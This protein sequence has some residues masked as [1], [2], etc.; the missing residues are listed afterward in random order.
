MLEFPYQV[1]SG[2][3]YIALLVEALRWVSWPIAAMVVAHVLKD[4]I[5]AAANRLRGLAYGGVKADFASQTS[6]A[7][8]L[9]EPLAQTTKTPN[10]LIERNMSEALKQVSAFVE[11]ELKAFPEEQKIEV[12]IV[13]VAAERLQKHFALAYA[14]IFGSQIRALEMLNQKNYA[15]L[16]SEASQMFTELQAQHEEFR[17][18]TLEKYLSFLRNF[19]LVEVDEKEIRLTPIGRDFVVWLNAAG[20]DKD[21]AL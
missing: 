19:Q 13:S 8:T 17:D 20:L 7:E 5:V 12:L 16:I 6:R 2:I 1:S 3:P 15:I 11:Q 21:R 10:A 18:W 4:P 14:N 9:D